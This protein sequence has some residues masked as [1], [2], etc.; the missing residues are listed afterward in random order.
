MTVEIKPRRNKNIESR[1]GSGTFTLK[2]HETFRGFLHS[3]R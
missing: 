3:L 1:K 2:L